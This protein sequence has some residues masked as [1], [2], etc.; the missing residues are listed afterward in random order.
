MVLDDVQCNG[1]FSSFMP[2]SKEDLLSERLIYLNDYITLPEKWTFAY[3]QLGPKTFLQVPSNG[4]A[5]IIS[6]SIANPYMYIPPDAAPW[7]Y[8]KYGSKSAS[9]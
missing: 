5:F 6:D 8:E 2:R 3:M 4:K 1:I 7:L 9:A